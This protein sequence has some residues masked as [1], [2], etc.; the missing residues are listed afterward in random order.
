MISQI[1]GRMDNNIM[2]MPLYHRQLSKKNLHNKH[3]CSLPSQASN[4]ASSV[5]CVIDALLQLSHWGRVMHICI[6]KLTIIGS[7]NGLSPGWHQAIIWTNAGILL[8]EHLGTNFSE[9]LIKINTFSFKKM[10]LKISS[11]KW[12]PFCL[13]LNV[14]LQ[15]ACNILLCWTLTS[16]GWS[17]KHVTPLLMHWSYIFLAL[18]HRYN[19]TYL[20]L[21]I[22]NIISIYHIKLNL[23][24]ET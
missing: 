8:I 2:V 1:T 22:T 3:P 18:T 5:G 24:Y 15:C 12:R 10:Y 17:K 21:S 13:S 7:D 9:I 6:R 23:F 20:Y 16:M 4:K 19:I 11:R 14:L